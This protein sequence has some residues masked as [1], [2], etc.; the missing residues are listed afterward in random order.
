MLRANIEVENGPVEFLRSRRRSGLLDE[1]VVASRKVV[2]IVIE[3]YKKG[4]VS[5]FNHYARIAQELVN[6]QDSR[7]QGRG[8]I[9][10][11]LIAALRAMRGAWEIRLSD[12][13]TLPTPVAPEQVPP[14]NRRLISK[15]Q[16]NRARWK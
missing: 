9:S 7:A 14:P 4:G 10:Q 6:Q 2:E 13:A 15:L 11:G 3:Q 12:Q 5:D 16:R 8:Q 1:S